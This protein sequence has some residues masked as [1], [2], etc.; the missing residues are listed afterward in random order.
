MDFPPSFADP[1][2]SAVAA[3]IVCPYG[4]CNSRDFEIVGHRVGS[5]RAFETEGSVDLGLLWTT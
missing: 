4:R 5:I 3:A 1:A 2:P